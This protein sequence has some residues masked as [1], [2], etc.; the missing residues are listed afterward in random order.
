M[1]TIAEQLAALAQIKE[2]IRQAIIDKGVDVSANTP[3]ADYATLIGDISGGGSHEKT[4]DFTPIIS[5]SDA[6]AAPVVDFTAKITAVQSGSGDPS[7]SNIRPITGWTGAQIS[8]NG[9]TV[10]VSWQSEAGTVYG[11]VLDATTGKMLVM[12]LNVKLSDLSWSKYNS[13]TSNHSFIADVPSGCVN[14]K[15]NSTVANMICTQYRTTFFGSLARWMD[16]DAVLCQ[17]TGTPNRLIIR[18]KRYT[19]SNDFTNN[20]GDAMIVYELAEPITYTLTP[21]EITLLAG[22][23]TLWAD[24][25]DSAM[26][27]LAKK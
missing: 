8:V 15:N 25:G 11:G 10:S 22:A 5:V 7:P 6:I 2:D 12:N 20:L 27:Y 4:I 9:S 13:D 1:S 21:T 24:T 23:N 26:T 3:F 18:D 16:L 17:I 14:I 19:T